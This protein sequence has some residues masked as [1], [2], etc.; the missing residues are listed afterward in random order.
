[1]RKKSARRRS[2]YLPTLPHPELHR[3]AESLRGIFDPAPCPSA[4]SSGEGRAGDGGEVIWMEKRGSRG[5]AIGNRFPILHFIPRRRNV[6]PGTTRRAGI[7]AGE[8]SHLPSLSLS[9]RFS[10]SLGRLAHGQ[11]ASRG[12]GKNLIRDG[13]ATSARNSCEKG[14]KEK[15]KKDLAL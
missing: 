12:T 5:V 8:F 6:F 3:N 2:P 11:S 15:K 13:S 10:L 7:F 14:G 4:H 1:M 9:F